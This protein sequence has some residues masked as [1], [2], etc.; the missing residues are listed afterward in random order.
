MAKWYWAQL[1]KAVMVIITEQ[2][3]DCFY[4][5]KQENRT[6]KNLWL[7]VKYHFFPSF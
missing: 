2:E 3:Q 4:A 7:V 1:S 5:Q 6:F